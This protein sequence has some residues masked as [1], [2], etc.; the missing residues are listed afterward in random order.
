MQQDMQSDAAGG[1]SATLNSAGV[2]ALRRF[3]A[4]Q[5]FLLRLSD[6]LQPLADPASIRCTINRLLAEQLGADRVF[7]SVVDLRRGLFW[8]EDEYVGEGLPRFNGEHQLSD[9]PAIGAAYAAARPLILNDVAAPGAAAASR[10]RGSYQALGAAA[11]LIV[12]VIRDG[13]VLA[14]MAVMTTASRHWDDE[15]TNLVGEV[16]ERA[17]QALARARAEAALRQRA[18]WLEGPKEAFQAAAGG[19]DLPKSLGILVRSTQA[20]YRAALSCA[21]YLA[22]TDGELR[23][24]TGAPEPHALGAIGCRIGPDSLSCGLAAHTAHPVITADVDRDPAWRPWRWLAQQ[25][26]YR[27]I[28]SFPIETAPGKVVGTFAMFFAEPREPT[29]GDFE[30]VTILTRAA[31][32]IIS[33]QQQGVERERAET[34]SRQN[35][36]RLRQFAEASQDVVW[37]RNAQ[38]LQWQYL[39]PAF[40]PIYGLSRQQVLSG[41]NYSGWLEL[42]VP[43]DRERASESID[44][45]VAGG[46]ETFDFRIRRP[47]DGEVRWMRNTDFPITDRNGKVVLIGGIGHDMTELRETEL[48]LRVLMEG[49]PQLVWRAAIDGRWTWASPQWTTYTGQPDSESQGWGWLQPVHPEDRDAARTAWRHAVASG[50]FEVDYRIRQGA[51]GDYRWFQTRATP[52][53]DAA[54]MIGEWLGTSTDIHEHRQLQ[55]RQR[56][57]VAE[58]Q[59][60][61]RN[62]IGVIHSMADKTALDS[63]DFVDFRQR[64]RDRLDALSRVQGLLS[65]LSGHDRVTFDELI[66]S[67]LSAVHGDMDRVTLDGPTGVRLR[68]SMLQTLALAIHELATNAVKYG[69]FAHAGARLVISWVLEQAAAD[70]RPWLHVDWRETGVAL[71]SDPSTGCIGQGRELLE[72]ALPYQ[73]S[74][75]TSFRL[76]PDGVHCTISMP[77][78]ARSSLTPSGA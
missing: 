29:P 71:G 75:R 52:V 27:A 20:A 31:A 7:Y 69:A 70:G 51:H 68:S 54:G 53:R 46:R 42:I 43:E 9:F 66:R 12:P 1:E 78:S 61:T 63:A 60:R 33:R 15:D 30:F 48:R 28:W 22:D 59:H 76:E 37:I 2:Q 24:L 25:H 3:A 58:L 8:C 10:L 21:F 65:R 38:T 55:E 36:E 45:V 23:H 41:N 17:W 35:E 74:A 16:G 5:T 64:F 34:E 49:I 6:A 73:L 13:V 4:R 72:Q 56:V 77:V 19:A 47:L 50:G 14:G 44:R 11:I 67:E 62:L 18:S 39:S 32:V 26:G 40:E 57:L